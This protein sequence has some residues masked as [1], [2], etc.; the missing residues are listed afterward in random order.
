MEMLLNC[1]EDL[2]RF[3]FIKIRHSHADLMVFTMPHLSHANWR[4]Q[5]DNSKI[6]RGTA[7]DVLLA[8]RMRLL[9]TATDRL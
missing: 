1:V 2:T 9:V 6:N 5:Q 4:V 3:R 8:E 7:R